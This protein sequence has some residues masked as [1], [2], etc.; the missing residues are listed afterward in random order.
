MPIIYNAKGMVEVSR[1]KKKPRK[2]KESMCSCCAVFRPFRA[3]RA[4]SVA[5]RAR[6]YAAV[7]G[8]AAKRNFPNGVCVRKFW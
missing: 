8:A 7:Q 1:N 3:F 6:S 4:G 5:Y 2:S